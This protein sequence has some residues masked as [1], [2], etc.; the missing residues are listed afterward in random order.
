MQISQ[1]R[2]IQLE[3]IDDSQNWSLYPL[4]NSGQLDR[5]RKSIN[6]TGILQ[7]PILQQIDKNSFRLINGR[8]R[9]QIAREYSWNPLHCHI[10]D[11]D[12]PIQQVLTTHL[13]E[14]Q[15]SGQLTTIEQAYFLQLC[16]HVTDKDN[17]L[18]T[19][20][21]LLGYSSQPIV[22]NKLL[23][24][25]RLE[26]RLQLLFHE[27][28]IGKKTATILLEL[29][30]SDRIFLTD[31]FVELKLGQGKQ[32]RLLTLCQDLS[33]RYN[34]SIKMI[35]SDKHVKKILQHQEMNIP[36]KTNQLLDLLKKQ[37]SPKYYKAIEHFQH[38]K[39]Q[40][41]LPDHCSLNHSPAF[42][43][44]EVI[45][46]VTFNNMDKCKKIWQTINSYLKE[47]N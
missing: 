18:N 3:S 41:D 2:L 47:K 29:D 1:Q 46:S 4:T 38:Q 33:R 24:F 15:L 16:L 13:I 35:L 19:F 37:H 39:I 25:L 6:Q 34:S 36:Q 20:L 44:D 30:P 40:L 21:P 26:D 8:K 7:P 31:L 28:I 32:Q 23:A 42:E 27:Q 14:Q 12:L 45:L 10:L 5:L 43:K 9:V 22:L 17:V 11:K